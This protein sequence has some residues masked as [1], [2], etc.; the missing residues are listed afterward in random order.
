M[1]CR[2][3]LTYAMQIPNVPN[4]TDHDERLNPH[5]KGNQ[6]YNVYETFNDKMHALQ[7]EKLVISL[8]DRLW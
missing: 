1:P 8:I 5:K 7:L 6:A 3:L 4:A 2:R